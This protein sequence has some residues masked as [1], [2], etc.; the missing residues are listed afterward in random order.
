[1]SIAHRLAGNCTPRS[2]APNIELA[3]EICEWDDHE[4]IE[5]LG[6]LLDSG[7]KKQRHDSLKALYEVGLRKP[8]LVLPQL[9][10]LFDQLEDKDNR[11]LWSSIY[12][13]L[14]VTPLVPQ[15]IFDA[16]P[17]I[18]AACA[19]ATV[20]GEDKTMS[21]LVE[22]CSREAFHEATLETMFET[23]SAAA[24]NQFPTYAERAEP[25]L[26]GPERARLATLIRSRKD[27]EKFP[28]KHKKMSK[29]LETLEG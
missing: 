22:L 20:V 27:L 21:I 19:R 11:V 29:L 18:M 2:E 24:T 23:I 3:K 7:R 5:E 28:A 17:M 1:M 16:L 4:A 13:L 15:K 9:Q 12:C 6:V 10:N 26:K 25:C 8:E 14:T